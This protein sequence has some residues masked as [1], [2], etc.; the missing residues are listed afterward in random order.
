[1]AA[2]TGAGSQEPRELTLDEA[3]ATLYAREGHLV[4]DRL[5]KSSRKPQ[6]ILCH[7]R[8]KAKQ[9]EGNA[10]DCGVRKRCIQRPQV[11]GHIKGPKPDNLRRPFPSD[12]PIKIRFGRSDN[13]E[14]DVSYAP[15]YGLYVFREGGWRR[16]Q[17][18][19]RTAKDS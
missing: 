9:T 19:H 3:I 11:G 7:G 14:N 17:G 1:M 12:A 10:I 16:I 8:S 15:G 6:R 13:E 5:A 2:T 4:V 18:R